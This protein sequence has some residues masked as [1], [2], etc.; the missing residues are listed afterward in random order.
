MLGTLVA[1]ITPREEVDDMLIAIA[2]QKKC[3]QTISM[4]PPT[5]EVDENLLV[6]SFD[7]SA[8]G[9]RNIGAYSAIVWK[10]PEWTILEAA[11]KYAT[12]LTVNE[13]EYNGMLLGFE[14]LANQDRRRVIICGDSN[15]VI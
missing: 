1:S 3:G 6:V 11:S 15:L 4:P 13:A 7:G 5:V 10:L 9:K 12:D 2:P 8:R 14:L